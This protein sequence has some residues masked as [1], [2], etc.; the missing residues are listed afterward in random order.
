MTVFG[1]GAF[2]FL[3][4]VFAFFAFGAL[5]AGDF[6][7][8]ATAFFAAPLAAFGVT[9]AFA[10]FLAAVLLAA[11]AAFGFAASLDAG[12]VVF[13]AFLGFGFVTFLAPALLALP[14]LP[15][16]AIGNLNDPD[17]PFPFVCNNEPDT[18]A[19]FKYFLINGANFSE[20]TL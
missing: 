12:L 2:G 15:L 6:S 14:V 20:S 17:A 1:L 11:D 18:T 4:G 5:L 9:A 8:F 19:D 13:A 16:P 7:F 10:A 3:V